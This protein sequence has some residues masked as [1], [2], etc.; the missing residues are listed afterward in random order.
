MPFSDEFGDRM[1]W[2]V[3][4]AS[5]SDRSLL[6]WERIHERFG[7]TC[8]NDRAALE[9]ALRHLNSQ[10]V[11]FAFF[12]QDGQDAAATL[13]HVSSKGLYR[14]FNPSQLPVAPILCDP[15]L[16]FSSTFSSLSKAI[17]PLVL[18]LRFS[19]F[20]PRCMPGAKLE[21]ATDATTQYETPFVDL[22]GTFDSYM[23]SRTTR[24]CKDLRRRTKKAETE[25]GAI[26]FEISNALPSVE[27]RAYAEL[28]SAG[29]KGAEGTALAPGNTQEVF[30]ND[31][32]SSLAPGVEAHFYK[33]W[34]GDQLAAMRISIVHRS[35]LYILKVTHN[36]T[37][38]ANSPG[39][40]M[41]HKV[42]ESMYAGTI[43]ARRIEFYGRVGEV[44]RPWMT[45]SQAIFH[46]LIYRN[47]WLAQVRRL[48]RRMQVSNAESH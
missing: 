31:W 8:L 35:T 34:I 41:L 32:M 30:Y 19:A 6:R 36:E 20:D 13:I 5:E 27:I 40:L 3:C 25:V 39:I 24:F 28:E 12:Q 46:G 48:T 38:R 4:F 16:N 45:G 22:E 2:T 29:W 9:S 21:N 33:L 7:V 11:Q 43:N 15:K 42:I 1:V 18:G 10:N 47:S 26:R 17:S 14:V 44:H 23:S 37:L